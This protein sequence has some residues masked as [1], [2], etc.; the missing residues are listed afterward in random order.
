MGYIVEHKEIFET[1]DHGVNFSFTNPCCEWDHE[2]AE[3][4][5]QKCGR[6][7]CY[8]CCESTNVDSGGKYEPDF[9]LCPGCGHDYYEE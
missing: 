8:S 4:I 7:F 2:Y 6:D 3:K 5:C 9:M 1:P